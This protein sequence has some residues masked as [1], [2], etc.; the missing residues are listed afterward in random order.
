M[1]RTPIDSRSDFIAAARTL[2]MQAAADGVREIW[3][4]DRDFA[5]WPL[6]EPALIDALTRWASRG[7]RLVL[8][9]QHFD[10]M[11]VRHPRFVTWRR[12]HDPNVDARSPLELEAN[13]HPCAMAAGPLSLEVFDRDRWQGRVSHDPADAVVCRERL[14]VILQRSQP[15]FAASTLGL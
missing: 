7:R 2:L 8:L 11:P 14:D 1:S 3:C 13:E 10:A 6:N 4:A 12:L 9:A 5:D 15:A